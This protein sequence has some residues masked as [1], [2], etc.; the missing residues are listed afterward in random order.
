M[1]SIHEIWR[2]SSPTM[3][4][5]RHYCMLL[6]VWQKILQII[7]NGIW[8]LKKIVKTSRKKLCKNCYNWPIAIYRS[9]FAHC[10]RG[11]RINWQVLFEC[12]ITF[13]SYLT[14]LFYCILRTNSISPKLQ[15]VICSKNFFRSFL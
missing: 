4:N 1:L 12:M 11:R 5:R 14:Q 8:K 2:T 9:I 13:R 3:R 15:Y 10:A 6:R 7:E